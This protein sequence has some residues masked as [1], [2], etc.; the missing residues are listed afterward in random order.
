MQADPASR[1]L[2]PG[3][4]NKPPNCETETAMLNS[5]PAPAG[6]GALVSATVLQTN[7]NLTAQ[8]A[9]AGASPD[10]IPE[11]MAVG[12]S[13]RL[14]WQAEA[15]FKSC[16]IEATTPPGV[17]VPATDGSVTTLIGSGKNWGLPQTP[18]V[19]GPLTEPGIYDFS[20]HCD[21][22]YTASLRFQVGTTGPH[23]MVELVTLVQDTV[24]TTAVHSQ[25]LMQPSTTTSVRSSDSVKLTWLAYN[26]R[27]NSC[28]LSGP[29]VTSTEETGSYVLTFSGSTDQV[30]TFQCTGDDGVIRGV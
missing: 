9:P 30:V 17:L 26:V 5:A 16:K 11:V 8:A 24:Q 29:G 2:K 25:S 21:D 15:K 19:L 14:G 27:P 6:T 10:P 3:D 28:N 12:Q 23:S 1:A 7:R 20:V 22:N 18:P 4:P 13:L